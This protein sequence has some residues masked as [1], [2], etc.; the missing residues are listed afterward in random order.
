MLNTQTG[1]EL[2]NISLPKSSVSPEFR[3]SFVLISCQ[4]ELSDMQPASRLREFWSWDS[5]LFYSMY[6]VPQVRSPFLIA[7]SPNQTISPRRNLIKHWRELR[8]TEIPAAN[9]GNAM[10]MWLDNMQPLTS[11]PRY[12]SVT[13]SWHMDLKA[14]DNLKG[15]KKATKCQRR[16][17]LT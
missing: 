16:A 3:G 1:S 9:R 14:K 6:P 12:G 8:S 17:K 7:C 11:N 15:R 4:L 2:K 10:K 5:K 13:D